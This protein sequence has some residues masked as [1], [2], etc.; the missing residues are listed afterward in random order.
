MSAADRLRDNLRTVAERFR[1]DVAAERAAGKAEAVIAADR[2][3]ALEAANAVSP[4]AAALLRD[5]L[6]MAGEPHDGRRGRRGSCQRDVPGA[7]GGRMSEWTA[8]EATA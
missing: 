1:R 2:R 6:R 5:C 4:V 3:Q 7:G 8:A